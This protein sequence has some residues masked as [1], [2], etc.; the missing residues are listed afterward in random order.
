[1]Y[2]T[3]REA[4]GTAE[5]ALDIADLAE[6][7]DQL[8][9]K[10]GKPLASMLRGFPNDPEGLVVLINGRNVSGKDARAV[11]LRDGD[12]VSIFPPVSGG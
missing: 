8:G 1:M 5:I 6:V 11:K 2:A 9:A 4:A 3:V 12:E 10:L 7:M